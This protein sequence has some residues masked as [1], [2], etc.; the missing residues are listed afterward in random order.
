MKFKVDWSLCDGNGLC[1]IEAPDLLELNDDDE[2]I[3]LRE[4]FGEEYRPAAE[5][6]TQ[7]CPK[8]AIS[9]EEE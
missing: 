7:V 5:K 8:C 9:I 4:S 1:A 3:I 2:L 6:A